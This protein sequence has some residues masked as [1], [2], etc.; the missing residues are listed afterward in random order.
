MSSAVIIKI[1]RGALLVGCRHDSQ[2]VHIMLD[3]LSFLHC[4][5]NVL[6]DHSLDADKIF[7]WVPRLGEPKHPN[8]QARDQ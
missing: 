8:L 7:W 3:C 6:L 2:A 1:N 4:L 5:H